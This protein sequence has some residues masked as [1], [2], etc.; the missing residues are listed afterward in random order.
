MS[1]HDS[2]N[3][4]LSSNKLLSAF[5]QQ[6]FFVMSDISEPPVNSKLEIL[7]KSINDRSGDTELPFN[8]NEGTTEDAKKCLQK[9]NELYLQWKEKGCDEMMLEFEIKKSMYLC[10]YEYIGLKKEQLNVFSKQ[11]DDFYSCEDINEYNNQQKF[12]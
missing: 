2:D 9:L 7:A 11:F 10:I 4:K 5:Q 8:V 6:F 3:I 1:S 12:L